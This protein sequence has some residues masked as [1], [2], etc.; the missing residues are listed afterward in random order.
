MLNLPGNTHTRLPM[1]QDLLASE[2]PIDLLE[3]EIARLGIEIV[4]DGDESGVEDGEVDVRAPL[5]VCDA[6]K[7]EHCPEDLEADWEAELELAVDI[8]ESV[9]YHLLL[10]FTFL[11]L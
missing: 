10:A 8:A 1:H 5:D 7:G 6:D 11:S 3:S 9:V 2:Q 4:D